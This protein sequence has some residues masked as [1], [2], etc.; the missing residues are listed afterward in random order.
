M[1]HIIKSLYHV[2]KQTYRAESLQKLNFKLLCLLNDEHPGTEHTF[3]FLI[4]S[5]RNNTKII[6]H[7]Y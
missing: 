7:S 5:A 1:Q 4:Y 2:L 6:T 3:V